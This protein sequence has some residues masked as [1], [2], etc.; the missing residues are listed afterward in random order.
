LNA[1]LLDT[2]R[3]R[4]MSLL[5][6]GFEPF[7]SHAFNPSSVVAQAA[8]T[9]SGG[10]FELLPVS[11]AAARAAG[12]VSAHYD[13]VVHIGLAA[14]TAW[15]RLE[16]FAHN[17][18]MEADHPEQESDPDSVLR[19]EE[20]GPLALETVVPLS[21][22][23]QCL[24]SGW[25]VRHSRD[26]GTYVCNATYYWSLRLSRASRVL[27]VHVPAWNEHQARLFG[28]TLAAGV[29]RSIC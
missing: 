11:F 29:T 23:R 20:A 3:E 13:T 17:L 21:A 28:E 9:A 22:L 15:V 19:L 4:P 1:L 18:R 7:G 14:A 6:T 10:S 2:V 26:A 8:A 24:T 12:E 27:F 16:R 5:F 25:D